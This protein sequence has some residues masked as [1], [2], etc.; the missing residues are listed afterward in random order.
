MHA[1]GGCGGGCDDGRG[2]GYGWS[3]GC[4]GGNGCGCGVSWLWSGSS[5]GAPGWT[6]RRSLS[7]LRLGV[8]SVR[9]RGS[10]VYSVYRACM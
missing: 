10:R 6:P 1:L 4:V 5:V 3:C 7:A 2:D 8:M 9:A